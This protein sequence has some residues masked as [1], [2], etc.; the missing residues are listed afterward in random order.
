M[1]SVIKL[2]VD[3]NQNRKKFILRYN[4]QFK[5]RFDLFI[6]FM[7]IFTCFLIPIQIS[8]G[9]QFYTE[10]GQEIVHTIDS[11]IDFMFFIDLV[12]NFFTSYINN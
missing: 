11:F 7:A 6:V 5:L 2:D 8:F 1:K 3:D 12:L 9:T 10:R 4:S